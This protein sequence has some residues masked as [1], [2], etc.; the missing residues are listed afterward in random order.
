MH[1]DAIKLILTFNLILKIQD[2]TVSSWEGQYS[3]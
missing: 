2:I 3:G 1:N